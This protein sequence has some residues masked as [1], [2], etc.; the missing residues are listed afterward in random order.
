MHSRH[1]WKFPP[2]V[3]LVGVTRFLVGRCHAGESFGE[4]ALTKAEDMTRNAS[5]VT[6][7]AT[8]CLVLSKVRCSPHAHR[9][10]LPF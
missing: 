5:V 2:S 8:D 9:R 7:E 1:P 3:P 4:L 10:F 6:D